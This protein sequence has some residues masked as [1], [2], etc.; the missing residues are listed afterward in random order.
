MCSEEDRNRCYKNPKEIIAL[1]KVARSVLKG[2]KKSIR[3]K[4][5]IKLGTQIM[6]VPRLLYCSDGQECTA[7]H[8][9][10]VSLNQ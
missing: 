8:F 4:K 9:M 5:E 7:M 10:G 3:I 2:E 1:E 6:K